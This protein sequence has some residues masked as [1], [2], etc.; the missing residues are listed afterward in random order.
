MGWLTDE[1]R[2]WKTLRRRNY[3]PLNPFCRICARARRPCSA[4]KM[5]SSTGFRLAAATRNIMA[6]GVA[7]WPLGLAMRSGLRPVTWLPTL[8]PNVAR[9]CRSSF[10]GCRPAG[11]ILNAINTRLDVDT[12]HYIS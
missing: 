9:P 12:V 7:G 1:T 11:A 8:L 4:R 5:R 2:G 6:A 3:T 10:R